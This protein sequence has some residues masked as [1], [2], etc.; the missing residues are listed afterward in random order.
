[1]VTESLWFFW[2]TKIEPLY[3]YEGIGRAIATLMPG[4]HS[5]EEG[6]NDTH[7]WMKV[8]REV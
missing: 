2:S 6:G 8:T 4:P 7:R 1:M 5:V 3:A